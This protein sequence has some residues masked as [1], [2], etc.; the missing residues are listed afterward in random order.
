MLQHHGRG[1][2]Q[3]GRVGH[4][5]AGDIR[6][7]AVYGLEDGGIGADVRARRHAQAPHQPGYQVGQDVAEQVGRDQHV[8]LPR[9]EHQLHRAGIDDDRVQLEL[10]L[11]LAL[12]QVQA[13]LQEDAGQRLH[14]V[15]LVHDRH[16]LAPGGHRVLEGKFQ[17]PAAAGAGVDACCHGHRMRVVVDL[18]VVLVADV[19]AFEV[20]AHHHQVDLVE[21]AA[22]HHGTCRAQI[23]VEL[24]LL[25]QAHVGRAVAAARW[26]F[27]WPLQRQTRAPDAVQNGGGQGVAGGFH[28]GQARD[29]VVEVERRAQRVEHGQ[30]G[31]DDFGADAVTGN[32]GCGNSLRHDGASCKSVRLSKTHDRA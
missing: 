13:G 8:E 4:V 11:V 24:E 29:L 12:V 1:Q 14:D 3:C 32:E 10:A 6:R 21:A 2:Q 26:C 19:Q 9:V 18:H 17:Q 23:G 28:A 22:G 25:A 16:L 27:Q 5:L 15:R 31:I 30:C 20:L 7:R